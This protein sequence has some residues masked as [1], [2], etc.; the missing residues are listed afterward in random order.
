MAQSSLKSLARPTLELLG[1]IGGL[2]QFARAANT[3]H[4]PPPE[5]GQVIGFSI[6]SMLR[7]EMRVSISSE[8]W[9]S[10]FF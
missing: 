6:M 8:V 1:P 3:A 2:G 9:P 10:C 4:G 7:R 5:M